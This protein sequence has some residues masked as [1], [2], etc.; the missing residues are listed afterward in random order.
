MEDFIDRLLSLENLIDKHSPHIRRNPRPASCAEDESEEQRARRAASRSTASTCATTS[1]RREFLEAQRKKVEDEKQ[2]RRKQASPS[3]RS[4]TCCSSCSSTRR[5]SPGS[6]RALHHPRRGLLLR[7][8]GPDEDHE[9]GLGQLLALHHHDPAGAAAI[10][11]VIDYADHHSGTMATR[12]GGS[13]RTSSAS[14][15]AA[16]SRSAGTRASSARSGT[17]ATTCE[18]RRAWDKKLGLGREKIFEV[19][20]HYNDVTFIDTFLTARVR[21]SSRSCS[22]TASTTSGTRGRSSTASSAR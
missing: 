20:K 15:S 13:T 14:S 22:S 5:W 2:R 4:A 11:E 17:S 1:T 10:D 8:A 3:G 7:P 19:R 21:A 6:G 9:R 18:T 12:P 16:T